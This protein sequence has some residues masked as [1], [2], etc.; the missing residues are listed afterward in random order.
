V[1]SP[2]I[3]LTSPAKKAVSVNRVI[4]L[5]EI[6]NSPPETPAYSETPATSISK[7]VAIMPD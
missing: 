4:K 7:V 3:V 5:S 1:S 6:M 2:L